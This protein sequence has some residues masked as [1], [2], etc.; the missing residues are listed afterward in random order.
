MRTAEEEHNARSDILLLIIGDSS[1][2]QSG[3]LSKA[4]TA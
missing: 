4:S 1:L 2:Y 3:G